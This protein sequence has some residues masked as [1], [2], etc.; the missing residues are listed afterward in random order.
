LPI[1]EPVVSSIVADF[2]RIVMDKRLSSYV[3]FRLTLCGLVIALIGVFLPWYAN[4]KVSGNAL[5]LAGAVGPL[6]PYL[7]IAMIVLAIIGTTAVARSSQQTAVQA[8]VYVR[9]FAVFFALLALGGVYRVLT[10]GATPTTT[11]PVQALIGAWVCGTGLVL[12]AAGAVLDFVQLRAQRWTTVDLVLVVMTAAL[13]AAALLTLSFIKLSPG[14]YLRPA[15]ALQMPFG[16]LFGIPGCIGIS[17]GNLLADLNQGLAPHAMIMGFFVNFLGAFIPY[18]LVSNAALRTRRSVIEWTVWAVLVPS[19]IVG[20]SIWI[21]V[22][23]GLT[24]SAIAI[25]F[26]PIT[27]LNTALPAAL[28]GPLLL[29]LLYPFVVRAGL[30]RGREAA[31][32]SRPGQANAEGRRGSSVAQG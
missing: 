31:L 5:Q 10:R 11:V 17:L 24:P 6:L 16:I 7:V 29:K 22:L 21:N 14:T 32:D 19:L 30:Y 8:S 20:G 25:A 27:F 12:A 4:A 9:F 1:I 28:L 3:G 18:A 13:Y 26:G 23:L 15:N 2:R